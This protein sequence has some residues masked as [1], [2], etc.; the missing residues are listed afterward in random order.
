M[1]LVDKDSKLVMI[2][3]GYT[4]YEDMV[5]WLKGKEIFKQLGYYNHFE[6]SSIQNRKSGIR[7]NCY[8][9]RRR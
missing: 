8:E 9:A 6:I 7:F 2:T 3:D 1:D 5:Q 4:G